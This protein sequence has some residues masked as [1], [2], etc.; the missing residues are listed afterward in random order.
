MAYLYQEGV[1]KMKKAMLILV[2]LV[3]VLGFTAPL[4]A[5]PVDKLYEGA[6]ELVTSPYHLGKGIMDGVK[7]K[8]TIHLPIGLIGGTITG[9]FEMLHHG[10]KGLMDVVTFPIT[11]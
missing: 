10:V 5:G 7:D 1:I 9:A 11:K 2:A 8:D 6:K 4:Y 3:F